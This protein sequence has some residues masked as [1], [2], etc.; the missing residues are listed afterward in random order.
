MLNYTAITITS[1]TETNQKTWAFGI[2]TGKVIAL[3]QAERKMTPAA[4]KKS[5]IKYLKKY[6]Y[7]TDKVKMEFVTTLDKLPTRFP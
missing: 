2:P 7:N 1:G 3:T 6:G 4:A 5:V